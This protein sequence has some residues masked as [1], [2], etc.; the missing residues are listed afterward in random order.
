MPRGTRVTV[1]FIVVILIG[2]CISAPAGAQSTV[3]R[4]AATRPAAAQ[5]ALGP[6]ELRLTY[7][8]NAGWEI[9][10]GRRVVLVDPF[11]TQFRRWRPGGG[12]VAPS[13][14]YLPDT[15][16]IRERVPRADYI[17]ITHGHSDHALDAG[18]I[19]RRTGAVIVGHETAANLAR[20]YDVPD[21]SLITVI[22]G[23][24]YD[25]DDFSVRVIPSIHSALDDKRY[26][27]NGRG[28]AG[29]A[30]RGLRAPLKRN[31]YQE[32]GSLAYLVRMAGHEVLV[33][34]S[35]NYLE[36]EMTGL[37]PDVALIGSNS[38][39]L[40]IHDFTGRL[41]RALGHPA[42][43][44]PNHA[45]AYGDP[46]PSRA[47]LADRRRFQ[48]E[49]AAAS[50]TTRFIAPTWFEPI[51]LP[52]RAVAP[53]GAS[54]GAR[55]VVTVPGIAPLVPAYSEAI[56]AGGQV[57]VSGMTGVKPG[58]QEIIEGGV[59]AQ[60]R[61]TL[62]NIRT[63]LQAAGAT[64]AQVTEC[65]VFLV[66]MADYAA[67]NRA[68]IEFFPTAPPARATLAVTALPRPAARVEIKCSAVVPE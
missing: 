23:E 8:G 15:A 36:R 5:S 38:Q 40:E 10:D 68:Y 20:A 33:M 65:T 1:A 64:M 49:V 66:D 11:L 42:V 37:R 62:E 29:K 4:S 43:V 16:F 2:A 17:L 52:A 30:P 35:M 6:G 53:P 51:V 39:R 67:M 45:D 24:D 7:L 22:G 58:T 56:R 25:F 61:Q 63:L 50:P 32:G 26:F 46:D 27:N 48:E 12:D 28:I 9:T 18:V 14:L 31:D 21:S 19:S 59:G 13:A 44:I 57:F 3:T 47:A 41:M 55:T 34:G 54:T 60:T